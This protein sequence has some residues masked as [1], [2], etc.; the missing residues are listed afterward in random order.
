MRAFFN[1]VETAIRES[2]DWVLALVETE[3]VNTTESD[4]ISEARSQVSEMLEELE[5]SP[6]PT[7]SVAEL[8][9]EEQEMWAIHV[10]WRVKDESVSN[11][12]KCVAFLN[13]GNSHDARARQL[14]ML[15]ER[16]IAELLT[17][18]MPEHEKNAA[19][20]WEAM[21]QPDLRES[22]NEAFTAWKKRH[23]SELADLTDI[24]KLT[25]QRVCKA[26]Q[27]G[28][29]NR[30]TNVITPSDYRSTR[31]LMEKDDDR[32][33]KGLRKLYPVSEENSQE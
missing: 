29:Q 27:S 5:G 9:G 32:L 30:Q 20:G 12:Y 6:T 25:G 26:F 11:P 33:L 13:N 14:S 17:I 22:F 3:V 7:Q 18:A 23:K 19:L 31:N 1:S 4:V 8:L 2:A 24:E 28:A 15:P 16:L 21:Y 10:E